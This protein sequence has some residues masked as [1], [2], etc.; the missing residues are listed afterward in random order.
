M[1]DVEPTV[2][3]FDLNSDMINAG[4]DYFVLAAVIDGAYDEDWLP[5]PD[6]S[7]IRMTKKF[8][9]WGSSSFG[10]RVFAN[11]AISLDWVQVSFIY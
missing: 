5:L 8:S 1:P 6:S 4:G 7:D 2:I 9:I 10:L 3:E 11:V